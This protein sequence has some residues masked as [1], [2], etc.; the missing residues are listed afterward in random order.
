ML[1]R[2]APLLLGALVGVLVG[3]VAWGFWQSQRN[4]ANMGL[5]ARD[6]VLLSFLVFG[7]LALVISSVYLFLILASR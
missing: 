4:E 7:A 3:L 5:T 2:T 1:I 6:D